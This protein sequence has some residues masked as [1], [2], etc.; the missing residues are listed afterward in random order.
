MVQNLQCKIMLAA[1]AMNTS[2]FSLGLCIYT[3]SVSKQNLQHDALAYSR[4]VYIIVH[5]PACAHYLCLHIYH[6]TLCI[7]NTATAIA[8]LY[9]CSTQL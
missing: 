3:G 8:Q 1:Y 6:H 7:H 4:A 5:A 9:R 2:S